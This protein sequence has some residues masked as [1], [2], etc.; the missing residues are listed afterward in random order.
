M[1]KG[2]IVAPEVNAC[3][4]RVID[5]FVVSEGLRQ[6]VLAAYTI[7]DGGFYP[8]SAVRL[9]L[10][11]KARAAVVRQQ[12][13]PL[14]FAAVL[15]HG[16]PNQSQVH[17]HETCEQLGSIR[18][19]TLHHRGTG[20]SKSRKQQW[21][22]EWRGLL[23]E[24]RN[25]EATVENSRTTS[26]SRAWRVSARWPKD[27][28]KA[29]DK[30]SA[31][32]AAWKLLFYEHPRPGP[33]RATPPQLEA[34][35]CFS[36]W[37]RSLTRGMLPTPCVAKMLLHVASKHVEVQEKAAATA[38]II[39]WAAWLAEGPGNSLKKLHRF[40]RVATGWTESA[41]SKG[42]SDEVGGLPKE[43]LEA[44]K[45]NQPDT[46]EPVSA[47]AEANDQAEAWAVQWG[48]KNERPEE[49]V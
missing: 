2:T 49:I 6:A 5:F 16:P 44:L 1:V 40:S 36:A 42:E 28:D 43:E 11:G 4:S 21:K 41:K 48:S 37:Q 14:G 19:R 33:A 18:K 38:S 47:Q 22:K 26:V 7:G 3:N 29:K 10:R 30:K 13:V 17:E 45:T 8:H 25:G 24:K 9:R 20:R 32:L 27:I 23:L 15:P 12:K 31:S 35:L 39:K 46:D 34:M